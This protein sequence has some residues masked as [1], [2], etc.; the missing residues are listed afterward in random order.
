MK[1][2][3]GNFDKLADNY[4]KYRPGYSEPVKSIILDYVNSNNIN[5][6]DVGAGTGIWTR[7]VNQDKRVVSVTAVEPSNNMR[8]FGK[9]HNNNNNINWIEGTAENTNLQDNS[10]NLI[11]M[12][13]SFHWAN[14]DNATKEFHR[15]LV[16]DGVFCALW[17]PRYIFNNPILVDIE[18]KITELNPDIK[19]VSS[20]KSDFV[21]NLTSKFN[22][23]EY[24]KDLVF[25][26]SRHTKE[27]TREQYIGAWL[28][29]N[30][31]QFQLGEKFD[32]FIEYIKDKIKNEDMIYAS[33]ITRA[34]LVRKKK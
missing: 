1:I 23:N 15:V 17:N 11:T 29:V 28:S 2:S 31:I 10:K 16:N 25:L 12:A 5:F 7:I 21:E 27:M 9:N 19:R 20:G 24:F 32:S 22:D 6:S 30:D 18:N 4:D 34:W 26:E 3:H 33:Y 13:S 14:F 8:E